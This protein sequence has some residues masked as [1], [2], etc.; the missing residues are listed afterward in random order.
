MKPLD[1]NREDDVGGFF[2]ASFTR[3][4]VALVARRSS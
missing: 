3:A 4:G 1:E 2:V